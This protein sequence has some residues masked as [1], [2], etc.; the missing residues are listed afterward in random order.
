MRRKRKFTTEKKLIYTQDHFSQNYQKYKKNYKDKFIIPLYWQTVT[1]MA[2]S[3]AKFPL[4]CPCVVPS[5]MDCGF[6]HETDFG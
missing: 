1:L 2:P 5:H 4:P 6:G 3:E